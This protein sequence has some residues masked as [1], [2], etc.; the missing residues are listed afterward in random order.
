MVPGGDSG[1]MN[2]QTFDINKFLE[3]YGITKLPEANK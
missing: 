3:V 2:L 1:G